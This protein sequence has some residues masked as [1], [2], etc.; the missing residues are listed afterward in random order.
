MFQKLIIVLCLV[1]LGI[2]SFL[3]ILSISAPVDNTNVKFN[4]VSFQSEHGSRLTFKTSSP[5]QIR[6]GIT[7][8]LTVAVRRDMS[9][10]KNNPSVRDDSDDLWI[11]KL[12]IPG[13]K[14]DPGGELIIS[15]K[16]LG[17]KN[18]TWNLHARI[19]GHYEG[20][21]WI[22]HNDENHKA[23]PVFAIPIEIDNKGFL[24]IPYHQIRNMS[25]GFLMG[26]FLCLI[27]YILLK[28]TRLKSES[29]DNCAY[30]PD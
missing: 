17:N 14:I 18:L 21:L 10:E 28:L 11:F 1:L 9:I 29:K 27:L 16:E 30:T 12:S 2:G 5:T 8:L 15:V 24:G 25:Y 20:T 26:S 6:S 23:V 13:M 3:F 22:Y 19:I 7:D 4:E